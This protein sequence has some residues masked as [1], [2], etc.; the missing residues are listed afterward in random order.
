MVS[1]VPRCC[2]VS[3]NLP[4]FL[5]DFCLW[6]SRWSSH[7]SGL[8]NI[9][10]ILVA[11]PHKS[12]KV[13]T[14]LVHRKVR[15]RALLRLEPGHR[16][17]CR[18]GITHEELYDNVCAMAEMD[19][20][21]LGMAALWLRFL[22]VTLHMVL[23]TVKVVVF[24]SFFTYRIEAMQHMEDIHPAHVSFGPK[25]EDLVGVFHC[26][27][28]IL[29]EFDYL[30]ASEQKRPLDLIVQPQIVGF[31]ARFATTKQLVFDIR[32]GEQIALQLFFD[33]GDFNVV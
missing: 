18:V 8:R 33:D 9:Q 14:L 22:T 2:V 19:P 20:E 3:D 30:L 12:V 10:S 16:G 32:G 27:F 29:S 1:V 28:R 4:V 13:N 15:P 5:A 23:F 26:L 24:E 7:E 6:R 11:P 21:E 25:T 17:H 31:W